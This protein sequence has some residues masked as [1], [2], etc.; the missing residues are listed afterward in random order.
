MI[1]AALRLLACI[2]A[3]ACAWRCACLMTTRLAFAAPR[4]GQLDVEDILRDKSLCFLVFCAAALVISFAT[5]PPCS[6]PG[7]PASCVAPAMSRS[8]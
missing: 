7:Q 8:T 2:L 3:C 5:T 1:P 4:H 6:T